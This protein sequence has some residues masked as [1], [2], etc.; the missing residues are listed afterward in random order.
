[1]SSRLV[2]GEDEIFK[3]FVRMM[4]HLNNVADLQG[5]HVLGS[6]PALE[7]KTLLYSEYHQLSGH[8]NC[9]VLTQMD[10]KVS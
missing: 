10:L 6:C 1:M 9:S 3:S 7:A 8:C 5:E 2:K 4:T